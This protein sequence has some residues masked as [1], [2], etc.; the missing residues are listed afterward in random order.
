MRNLQ[1]NADEKENEL[2][3]MGGPV[4]SVISVIQPSGKSS[5]GKCS[6]LMRE[7]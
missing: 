1:Q 4:P 2:A 3:K 7:N 5:V 6:K